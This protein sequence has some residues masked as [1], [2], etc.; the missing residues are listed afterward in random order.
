MPHR[1]QGFSSSDSGASHNA[2]FIGAGQF[3]NPFRPG[4][5]SPT[6]RGPMSPSEAVELY[7]ATLRG[8]VGRRYAAMFAR[9]LHGKDLLCPCPLGIPCHGDVLLRLAN[10]SLAFDQHSPAPKESKR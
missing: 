9:L 4:D 8:P 5:P 2:V 6:A 10:P 3:G 7:A 1:F